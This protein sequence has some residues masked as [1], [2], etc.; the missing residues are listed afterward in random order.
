[1]KPG[2]CTEVLG[3]LWEKG[4]L[5]LMLGRY[6][7]FIEYFVLSARMDFSKAS[8]SPKA[9]KSQVDKWG[10]EWLFAG[11]SPWLWATRRSS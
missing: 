9:F 8:L 1:M 7:T 10:W 5:A 4:N 3:N 6:L 11:E 2:K